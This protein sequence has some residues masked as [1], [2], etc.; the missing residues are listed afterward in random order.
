[1]EINPQNIKRL[2]T[3]CVVIPFDFRCQE[4]WYMVLYVWLLLLLF[5][6]VCSVQ[7]LLVVIIVVHAFVTQCKVQ[8]ETF[9]LNAALSYNKRINIHMERPL[10]LA[11]L[12][13]PTFQTL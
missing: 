7:A 10:Q 13:L 9:N 5:L 8:P 3:S 6:H 4:S 11:A 2:G 1:M 12:L